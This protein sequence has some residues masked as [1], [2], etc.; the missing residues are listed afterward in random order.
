MRN[1][2]YLRVICIMDWAL[3]SKFF[4]RTVG[5][6]LHGFGFVKTAPDHLNPHIP[7]FLAFLHP[8]TRFNPPD[9]P[10]G[11][12]DISVGGRVRILYSPLLC[13]LKSF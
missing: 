6:G 11:D 7:Y 2:I 12:S 5:F 1:Y 4:Y 10:A 8:E 9:E 13:T 3:W